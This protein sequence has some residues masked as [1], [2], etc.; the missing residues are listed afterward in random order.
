MSLLNEAMASQQNSAEP[1]ISAEFT[2]KLTRFDERDYRKLTAAR[3]RTIQR[4]VET[5]KPVLGVA[6]AVDA[7]CGVGF[8]SKM[9]EESGLNVCGF[10]GRSENIAEAKRR[11]PEI[12][13]EQANVED[14]GIL[15]LGRFDM[16]LCFGL[17]YHLENPL[18]AVRNLRGL[19]G[20]CLLLE[21]MC[22]PDE[23]PSML[24]RDEP[25][26]ADQG[27]ADVACYPS[28]SSLVKML[29]R[30]GFTNVYRVVPLPDHDD[31]CDTPEHARR[32]T[33]LLA[34]AAP[35]DVAGFRLFP[36][37]RDGQD[38]WSKSAPG[39][40][41]LAQRIE[42]FIASPRRRKYITLALRARRVFP[43]MPIPLRLGFGAWWLAER[44]HL[45][46]EL[47]YG[48]FEEAEQ[49]FVR[50]LLRPGM[51]VVDVGAHHG[52][53]TML[54]S[55]RVG[56]KG[57]VVAFEPSPRECGR[58]E[59]HMRVNRCRNV[60][61]EAAALANQNS[62]ANFYVVEGYRDACNSLRPPAV[63]DLTRTIQVPVRRLDDA[64]AARGVR[65]VDFVK[66][67]AEGAELE[68]LRG[69]EKL[70]RTAP[71][72]LILAEVQDLRTQPWNYKAR[73]IPLLLKAWNY[74]WFSIGEEGELRAASP[75]EE[76]YDGNFVAVPAE[77][78]EEF[79][80]LIGRV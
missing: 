53:Y 76:A 15:E 18:R 31:F 3:G 65:K 42:R 79:Q 17:L 4:V 34:T 41:S 63:P 14:A 51:T 61:L 7:G 13:F 45:D 54:S 72:P 25:R 35:L 50:R 10:D 37:P 39:K 19:T 27:L 75:D 77:R 58:F 74:R 1:R 28:E 59:R 64:L 33:V 62:L 80:P 66:L 22:L 16:V 30:A 68:V 29:Y 46:E 71:R 21:S 32:R 20:K 57:G 43:K 47:M 73:E 24:L 56:R 67:D 44:G 70:L 40:L 78:V 11:F 60:Q 8:F 23:K 49:R 12:P 36:E 5:L 6:T 55:K 48:G 9:L 2:I 69:A 38:P 52:L 26:A